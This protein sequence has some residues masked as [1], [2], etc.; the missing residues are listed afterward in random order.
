MKR[1]QKH[2]SVFGITPLPEIPMTSAKKSDYFNCGYEIFIAAI[3]VLSVVDM[4]LA[5][6]PGVDPD[7]VKVIYLI[8]TALT[9]FLLA[10]FIARFYVAP[11]RSFYF[12]RDFGWAD[13]LACAPY[14]RI[15]RLFRVFKAYRLIK[16]HGIHRLV[17]FLSFHRAEAALYFLVFMVIIIIE[18]GSFLVLVAESASSEANIRTATD[19]MWWAYTTITTV[20][21]GDK[22]PVTDHGRLVGMM[23][24]TMGVGVFATFAGYIANKLLVPRECLGEEQVSV[25]LPPAS[26]TLAE[27]KQYLT[28]REK[29][30]TE[31]IARL[32]HLEHLFV[33]EHNS[34]PPA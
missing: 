7:A 2:Y 5:V 6:A 1:I 33:T 10:D 24:M 15:L 28:E 25:P 9:L 23:I 34:K 19:A 8:N 30:D 11:S 3:S 31:I 26:V 17:R 18:I 29:I 32:A 22:Y 13:L 4:L 20:G 27:L 12:F 16:R 14:F 21:Y